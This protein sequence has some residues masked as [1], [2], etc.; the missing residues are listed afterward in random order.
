[1]IIS[2]ELLL[3]S[4]LVHAQNLTIGAL[5]QAVNMSGVF[6]ANFE[7]ISCLLLVF[8]LLTLSRQMPT[9]LKE[10]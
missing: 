8:L 5:E 3:P 7:H 4:R 10:R 9:G 1:M 6:I 2:I